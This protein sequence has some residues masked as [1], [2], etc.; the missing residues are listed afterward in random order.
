MFLLSALLLRRFV[1]R[2]KSP[3][4]PPR[5]FRSHATFAQAPKLFFVVVVAFSLL[6]IYIYFFFGGGEGG[7][8]G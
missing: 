4:K 2:S 3:D 5:A 6:Y 8:V 7:G 1:V